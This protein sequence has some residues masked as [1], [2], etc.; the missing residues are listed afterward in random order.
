VEPDADFH[1]ASDR[2]SAAENAEARS[3]ELR[4]TNSRR[5]PQHYGGRRRHNRLILKISSGV[6]AKLLEGSCG[7]TT[8]YAFLGAVSSIRGVSIV[9]MIIQLFPWRRQLD[10]YKTF[11]QFAAPFL[12][13]LP[14]HA[15]AEPGLRSPAFLRSFRA[16]DRRPVLAPALGKV[17]AG[18][19]R[20]AGLRSRAAN[21]AAIHVIVRMGG[22]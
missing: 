3:L 21:R 11:M 16:Q 22:I 9:L 18:G 5:D 14:R 6:P 10:N 17:F 7:I 20:G 2:R 1:G 12:D 19:K 13:A 15:V 8:L 4:R